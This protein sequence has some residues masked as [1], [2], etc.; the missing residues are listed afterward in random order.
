VESCFSVLVF[1]IGIFMN[2]IVIGSAGSALQSLDAEKTQRRQLMDRIITYM[3]KRKLPTYFQR[4]ILDFYDYMSEKHSEEGILT[5]LPQTIQLRLSLLLNREL[6]KN[7]PLLKQLELN[8]IISLMQTLQSRMYL[9][10]EYVFKIGDRAE[11]LYF[12]K[13]GQIEVLMDAENAIQM[14]HKGDMFGQVG[15]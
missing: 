2:A 1:L 13:S 10:G 8:T 14:L 4:I 6:V 12:V 5:D 9:P 11:C 7:I 15:G 3:K